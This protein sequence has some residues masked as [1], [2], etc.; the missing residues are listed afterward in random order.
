ME[1]HMK[2]CPECNRYHKTFTSSCKCGYDFPAPAADSGKTNPSTGSM[3]LSLCEMIAVLGIIA[4]IAGGIY[5]MTQ[6]HPIIGIFAGGG[7]VIIN[8]GL[9]IV[10]GEVNR[11][12]G[13]RRGKIHNAR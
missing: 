10:F 8:T 2:Q 9:M 13:E 3:I 11:I 7:G 4:S 1:Q 6:N 5:M 12:I